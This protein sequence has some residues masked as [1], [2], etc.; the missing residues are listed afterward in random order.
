MVDYNGIENTLKRLD[1][2]Y[3]AQMSDPQMPILFSKL[4]VLELCGWIEE[5]FD[6]LLLE[7]INTHIFDTNCKRIIKKIIHDNYG[8]QYEKH[9][10]KICSAVVGVNNWENII[11]QLSL[12]DFSIF[13]TILNNYSQGRNRAAH[14]HTPIGTTKS[15]DAP[16]LVLSNFRKIKKSV[17][18]IE[19]E[20]KRL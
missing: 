18:V 6:E 17:N 16:S 9:L 14:T 19:N 1:M 5:S 8:F 15:Y 13:Q 20:I 10:F 2:E 3:N 4:A 7:Y 12:S 11:D